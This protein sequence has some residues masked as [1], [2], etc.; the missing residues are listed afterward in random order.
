MGPIE[1]TDG[2][3]Y[4]IEKL[5]F[6]K[7]TVTILALINR[8]DK[9]KIINKVNDRYRDLARNHRIAFLENKKF[10]YRHILSDRVH[11][12][13]QIFGN[14]RLIFGMLSSRLNSGIFKA[15]MVLSDFSSVVVKTARLEQMFDLRLN[16]RLE[17]N[18]YSFEARLE[19]KI[20][21]TK[22]S[23]ERKLC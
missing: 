13:P 12:N 6:Y 21:G 22:H 20:S 23:L 1:T 2:I 16:A 7:L 17:Q 14:W 19:Q 18:T 9:W 5:K 15:S 10:R 4:L 3:N 11:P 8:K